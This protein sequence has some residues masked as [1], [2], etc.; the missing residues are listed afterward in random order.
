MTAVALFG[1]GGKMGYRLAGNLKGSR[2]SVRHVEAAEAGQRRL[3]DGLGLA[4]V[5]AQAAL[6]GA[7]VVILAVPDTRI[8][9][10]AAS[11]VDQ[12]RPGTM[13]MALDAAAPF[14]G[15][16]PARPDLTY[17]VTHPCHPPVFNDE[18]TMAA[19]T[20]LLRWCACQAAHRQRPDAGAGGGLCPRR[21]DRESDL[22]AGD[23]LA[24]GHGRADGA[25][26]AGPFGKR[27]PRHCS[28]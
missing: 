14:A 24:P 21:G 2:F 28:R 16:L 25:A 8:G 6:D 1:A 18:T 19:K 4:C 23:A 9:S 22:G 12:L 3:A 15:H 13:V 11:I 20:R 10:V 7:D 27:S 17:F 26:G 5:A